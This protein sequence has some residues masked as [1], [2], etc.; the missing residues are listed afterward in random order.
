[1][2]DDLDDAS[3]IRGAAALVDFLDAQ[4][5]SI[6]DAR[7]GTRLRAARNVDADFGRSGSWT[8]DMRLPPGLPGTA[9]D[10]RMHKPHF[11]PPE[12]KRNLLGHYD[13]QEWAALDSNQ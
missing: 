3:A 7:C 11:R 4:Q 10:P 12:G 6:A 2:I 9:P 5:R 13:L 8:A 1:M